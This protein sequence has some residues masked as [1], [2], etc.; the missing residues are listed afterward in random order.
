MGDA[1]LGEIEEVP[2]WLTDDTSIADHEESEQ[3]EE[4]VPI[5]VDQVQK[6][7]PS[8]QKGP[9]DRFLTIILVLL[10][11]VAVVIVG[12]IIFLAI[13]GTFVS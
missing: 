8:A 5:P 12:G 1:D 9:S 4:P 3:L 6:G 11:V 7:K 2:D 13:T 10:A